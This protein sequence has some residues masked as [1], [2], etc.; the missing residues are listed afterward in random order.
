MT[1]ISTLGFG[2]IHPMTPMAKIV[3]SCEV[4]TGFI[5]IVLSLGSVIG[6]KRDNGNGKGET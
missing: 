3:T 1:T 5:L 6:G 4:I 2:D